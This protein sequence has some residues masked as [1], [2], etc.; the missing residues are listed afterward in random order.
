VTGSR[1]RSVTVERTADQKRDVSINLG[2]EMRNALK[3]LKT[4]DKPKET[5][6]AALIELGSRNESEPE[7]M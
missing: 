1:K 5:P 7:E 6:V 3:R 4:T 2:D